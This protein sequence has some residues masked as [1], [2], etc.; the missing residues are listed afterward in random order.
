MRNIG[1]ACF[2]PHRERLIR[3]PGIADMI[4]ND[5]VLVR[6]LLLSRH[7]GPDPPSIKQVSQSITKLLEFGL[8]QVG[9]VS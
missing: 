8:V 9:G 6:K 7:N 4:E 5:V 1:L 3:T 2:R